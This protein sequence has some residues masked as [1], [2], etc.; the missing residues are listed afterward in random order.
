MNTKHKGDITEAK[1]LAKFVSMGKSVLV[2]FGDNKRYDLAIDETGILKR[3]Q[4]KTG[5]IRKGAIAFNACSTPTMRGNN[6]KTRGYKNE[7]DLF[8]VYVPELDKIYLI[9]VGDVGATKVNLRLYPAKNNQH[10]RI[11]LASMYEI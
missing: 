6:K 5:H 7:A 8:A 10:K 3:V 4:C 2:P 11:R 9:P 1:C